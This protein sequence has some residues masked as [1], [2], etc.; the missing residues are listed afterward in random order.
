[1]IEAFRSTWAVVHLA[2]EIDRR[3]TAIYCFLEVALPLGVFAFALGL[4]AL[5]DGASRHD[6]RLALIGGCVLAVV[7]AGM[8][9]HMV[10]YQ[11]EGV[12]IQ[13]KI[14]MMADRRIVELATSIPVLDKH[15]EIEFQSE[16]QLLRD[17][18]LTISLGLEVSFGVALT[19]MQFLGIA[20]LL[21]RLQPLLLSL[22]VFALPSLWASRA[23]S[24]C[25]EESRKAAAQ[26][27]RLARR[28]LEL[29]TSSAA[30][31]EVR[32]YGLTHELLERHKVLS[33]RA[34]SV[35]E[36]AERK[37]AIFAIIGWTVFALGFIGAVGLV[38]VQSLRGLATV[39]DVLMTIVLANQVSTV[40]AR[41]VWVSRNYARL[42]LAGRRMRWLASIAAD[43]KGERTQRS[44]VP[45]SL[46]S[47]IRIESLGFRYP[48]T[49]R[50]ALRDV[51]VNLRPGSVV[52]VV[53]ENG[54]GKST[55]VNL[56][57]GLYRPTEGRIL[58]DSVDL[59]RFDDRDWRDRVGVGYQDSCQFEFHLRES[60][61]VGHLPLIEDRRAIWKSVEVVGG[62]KMV[63]RLADGL[64]T[65]LGAA[66]PMGVDL[67]GGQW[68][69]VALG[70]TMMRP[71][72]LLTIFDEPTT[73]LDPHAEHALFEQIARAARNDQ[74]R[75]RIT[76]LISHRFS[77]VRAADTIIVLDGGRLVEIGSHDEL[78]EQAGLYAQLH[79]MQAAAYR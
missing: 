77:T 20:V 68:Q 48:E 43:L 8:V 3:L 9:V 11:V 60:I 46:H 58:V 29:A 79:K 40:T 47:G 35:Q 52:A 69:T 1:V 13:E 25:Q 54:A 66:W 33:D 26:D 78:I 72:P 75:D 39:G 71:H 73:A 38:V 56:L 49:E 61:G 53:G 31:K 14:G 45:S 6:H 16:L 30:G 64:E 28:V 50:W 55:L 37:G 51:S 32:L 24:R 34:N 12:T 44:V 23:E 57:C 2:W 18:R 15:E 67:S 22:P 70:R 74:G 21:A 7:A 59:E 4:K 63:N 42:L 41:T 36:I 19:A 76:I 5:S 62:V 27:T 65:Q 10:M 17:A